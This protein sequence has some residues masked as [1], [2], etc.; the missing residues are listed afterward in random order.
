M[1]YL[2]KYSSN[3][4]PLLYIVLSQ[5][6][7]ISIIIFEIYMPGNAS[8]PYLL[9]PKSVLEKYIR[10]LNLCSS[11]FSIRMRKTKRKCI[12]QQK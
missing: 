6:M 11:L 3:I 10:L 12:K 9:F 7:P 2:L 1:I 4:L 8:C 5:F